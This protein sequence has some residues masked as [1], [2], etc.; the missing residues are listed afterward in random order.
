MTEYYIIYQG[1]QVGPMSIDQLSYYGL[2]YNSMVWVQGMPAWVQAGNLPE[3]AEYL[4]RNGCT[5]PPPPMPQSNDG[6]ETG[7]SGK[8][9]VLAGILAIVLGWLGVQYFYCGKTTAGLIS[10]LLSAVTCG[11]I[12]TIICVIQGIMM[13]SMKQ[14]DFEAKY[15]YSQSTFPLF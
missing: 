1:R 9:H 7:T 11:S 6:F 4:R 15:V 13:I 12:W 14:E 2:N 5:T 10:I 8:S 3:L